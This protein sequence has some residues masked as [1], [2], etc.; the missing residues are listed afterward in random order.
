M[1]QKKKPKLD[2]IVIL[3]DL[4]FYHGIKSGDIKKKLKSLK[5]FSLLSTKTIKVYTL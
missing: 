4:P 5:Q 3:A 1:N 2:K